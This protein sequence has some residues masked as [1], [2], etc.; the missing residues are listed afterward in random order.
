M[1][2]AKN[3]ID[4]EL[5]NLS[6]LLAKAGRQM[7]F[8]LPVGYFD[9]FPGEMAAMVSTRPTQSVPEGYFDGFAPDMV[10]I[11]RG[12]AVQE[13][14]ESLAPMLHTIPKTMPYSLPDGYFDN[15][16]PDLPAV[17]GTQKAR[18]VP[19]GRSFRWK[20][21][22]A[23]AALIISIGFAWKFWPSGSNEASETALVTNTPVDTLLKVVD[24]N[25]LSGYLETEQ[26]G[27]EF[28]SLLTMAQQD[29]ETGVKQLTNDELKWYLENQAVEVPG[30]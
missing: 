6:A 30:S 19:F 13:E 4:N 11:V 23:A 20:Q 27:S 17:S 3:D 14:L 24:A 15:W 10:K 9:Q 28:S 5:D 29:I 8:G 2:P 25:S 1:K 16:Q 12:K 26:S 7:P 22:A 21:W 18:V